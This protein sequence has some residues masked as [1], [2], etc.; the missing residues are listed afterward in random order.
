MV[1]ADPELAWLKELEKRG[2]IDW[3]KVKEVHESKSNDNSHLTGVGAVVVA[4]V[5]TVLTW[6]AASAAVASA[7]NAA[8]AGAGA[9]GAFAAGTAAT[10]TAAAGTAAAGT[11]V[12]GTAVAGTVVTGTVVTGTVATAGWANIA[13]TTVLTSMASNATVSLINN[14]GDL[15]V[16]L[17]DTFSDDALKGYLVSAITAGLLNYGFFENGMS[18]TQMA[19]LSAGPVVNGVS[20][21]SGGIQWSSLEQFGK[22]AGAIVARGVVNA[23]VSSAIQQTYFGDSFV[24]CIVSDYASLGAR[25]IGLKWGMGENKNPVLQTV[26]HSGLGATSAWLTGKD[27]VAGAIGGFVE[28]VYS[29]LMPSTAGLNKHWGGVDGVS[30]PFGNALY[31]GSAA[32]MA[33]VI[34]EAT[35]HDGVTAATVA[36]N[37]ALNNRQFTEKEK[38][39]I[40]ALSNGDAEAEA[41]L[42]A[43]ACARVGCYMEFPE[44]S[45]LYKTLYAT[46]LWGRTLPEYYDAALLDDGLF[47]Y[48]KWDLSRDIGKRL[49]DTYQLST[50]S[51][52]LLQTVG[53]GVEAAAGVALLPTCETVLGCL[54]AS[55]L[56][57]H[58]SDNMSTGG[59]TVVDGKPYDTQT[60]LTLQALG[61]SH[62][63]ATWIELT[64][65]VGGTMAA[66]GAKVASNAS[67]LP[68]L[69]GGQAAEV[70]KGGAWQLNPIERGI[71]IESQLA[72]TEYKT[73]FNVGQ[74]NN[75]KFPL[76]DFQKDSM[77]VSLKSVDTAGSTWFGRMTQHIDDLALAK[78]NG[79][80]VNGNPA[81]LMLDLRVQPGGAAAA[82]PL[83]QYG[84]SQGIQVTIKE[85]P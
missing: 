10:G 8:S 19:G 66:A 75:G 13:I 55:A 52:G 62:E 59:R 71:A 53:G 72:Q 39:R 25:D 68:P 22:Q 47:R 31:T 41:R 15:G 26:A 27:P 64:F 57:A 54:A 48:T 14:K 74:L 17:Q 11:A 34:A 33:G 76:V 49:N 35:G 36:Q 46:A 70:A 51:N 7:A 28:S 73:W 45:D 4:I 63:T 42:N 30:V 80:S 29:N 77:L 44:D 67:K 40:A 85:F 24:Q 69:S 18:L 1:E 79:A 78:A 43:A 60:N 9:T 32:L 61:L 5:V 84:A 12:A 2:D 16:A 81:T 23:G 65:S 50:R 56:L 21:S 37:A 38:Q 82:K 6:G 20:Q 58:G 3:R 83:A